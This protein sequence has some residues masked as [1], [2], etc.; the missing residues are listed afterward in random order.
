MYIC[1]YMYIYFFKVNN[2][3]TKKMYKICSKLT[4]RTPERRWWCISHTVLMCPFLT[5]TKWVT[6]VLWLD[7]YFHCSLKLF[8][9][10]SLKKKKYS[11]RH[12]ILKVKLTKFS[13]WMENFVKDILEPFD[14]FKNQQKCVRSFF[15][16]LF[17]CFLFFWYMK[18]CIFWKCIQY[19]KYIEIKRKW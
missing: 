9:T 13:V 4:I 2:R 18:V 8:E 16:F 7:P 11:K 15:L 1:I 12:F 5:V 19:T 6:A 3:N 10:F 17:F 14:D